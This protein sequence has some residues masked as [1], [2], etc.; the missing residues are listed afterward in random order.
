M[1]QTRSV[2][3]IAVNKSEG[4]NHLDRLHVNGKK[5]LKLILKKYGMNVC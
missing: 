4:K 3:K 2:Y 5:I 1:R